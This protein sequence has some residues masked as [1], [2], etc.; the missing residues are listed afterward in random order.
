MS[1]FYTVVLWI[2][3]S[4]YGLCIG[5]FLNVVIYRVPEKMSIVSPPS[6]CPKCGYQLKAYDN[7]PVFSYIFLGGKCRNC[8][9][10]ISP[11]YMIVELTNMVLWMLSLWCFGKTSLVYAFIAAIAL[12]NAVCIFFIDL[13]HMLIFDRFQIIF[14]LLGIVAMFFDPYEKPLSHLI[15]GVAAGGIFLLIGIIGKKVMHREALGGGD[16]KLVFCMGLFLGWRR[17]LLAILLASLVASVVLIAVRNKK[18]D[19]KGTEYPFGPFLT[20]G[21]AIAL[22]FGEKIISAYLS[23]LV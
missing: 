18:G 17:T 6:H 8:R 20:A 15:G 7:I 13:D 23:L 14:A 2:L 21:F 11:R 12:S 1:E 4:I 5:S 3:T 19:E 10:K 16:I 9:E 22:L